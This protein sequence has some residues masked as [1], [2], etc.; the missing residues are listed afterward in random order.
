MALQLQGQLQEARVASQVLQRQMEEEQEGRARLLEETAYA[1]ESAAGV[2]A[3]LRAELEAAQAR[4]T[5]LL[6]D[7]FPGR[8]ACCPYCLSGC[9]KGGV[10]CTPRL[11]AGVCDR[12]GGSLREGL[13]LAKATSLSPAGCNGCG[14]SD[15]V[16]T[17][18]VGPLNQPS[19]RITP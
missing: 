16:I 9:Q 2:E 1:Q 18:E 11:C 10:S 5:S 4:R 13:H 17:A 12:C 6:L 8:V 15:G 3:A 14:G 7:S 19:G